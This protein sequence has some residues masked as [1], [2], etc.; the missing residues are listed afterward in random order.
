MS[1]RSR[2]N[3]WFGP[4]RTYPGDVKRLRDMGWLLPENDCRPTC[5]GEWVAGSGGHRTHVPC[6]W[7]ADWWHL[8]D[9][10][11]YCDAHLNDYD[12][13]SALYVRWASFQWQ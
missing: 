12:R 10:Y 4:S 5:A 1:A 11:A 6:F 7:P 9:P 13:H 3:P 8:D 2:A